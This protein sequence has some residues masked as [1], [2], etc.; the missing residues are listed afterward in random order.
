MPNDSVVIIDYGLG[1]LFSLS[2]ALAHVGASPL[3]TSDPKAV[4]RAERLV[5]PG[6]GAF[7]D[8]MRGLRERG[9]IEPVLEAA[10]AGR[11]LLGICLGMQLL[12]SWSDEFGRHDGLNLIPGR[13]TRLADTDATG[14]RVKVPHIGWAELLAPKP[15]PLADPIFDGVS[16]R[17]A[18]YFVHS[19]IP[20]PNDATATIA[21]FRH[22]SHLYCAAVR[23]GNVLGFQCHPEKSGAVGLKVLRNFLIGGSGLPVAISSL[24]EKE[25][26][27]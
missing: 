8:G 27:R 22:G 26:A 18:M 21:R 4:R 17:D 3:V 13:V 14:A 1:N 11:P 20:E 12:F 6:V 16:E 7:A 19:Y 23:W 5:L 24:S 25:G 9:L 10:A 15:R 2:R